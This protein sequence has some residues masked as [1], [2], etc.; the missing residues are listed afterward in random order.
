MIQSVTQEMTSLNQQ[1]I[2][3]VVDLQKRSGEMFQSIARQ[4]CAAVVGL[5]GAVTQHRPV[6]E[7]VSQQVHIFSDIGETLLN[8][9]LDMMGSFQQFQVHYGQVMGKSLSALYYQFMRNGMQFPA[10]ESPLQVKTTSKKE[11]VV[12]AAA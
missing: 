9:S 12:R 3:T 10:A 7:T 11:G 2:D 8:N 4:Q 1:W 5:A 6:E